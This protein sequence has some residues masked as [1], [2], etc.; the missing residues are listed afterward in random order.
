MLQTR[1]KV[2]LN[3]KN[4]VT[5]V[6]AAATVTTYIVNSIRL[7]DTVKREVARQTNQQQTKESHE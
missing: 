2:V 6:G 5:F 3:R 1:A 4:I 7:E